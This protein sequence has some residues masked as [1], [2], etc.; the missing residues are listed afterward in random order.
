MAFCALLKHCLYVDSVDGVRT[1]MTEGSRPA[2]MTKLSAGDVAVI[3]A[4][5]I[6]AWPTELGTAETMEVDITDGTV[7]VDDGR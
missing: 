3:V 5:T 6:I 2:A 7:A 4:E 1:C